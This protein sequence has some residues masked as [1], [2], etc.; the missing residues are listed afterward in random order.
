MT[1][2]DTPRK[3]I[4]V[5]LRLAPIFGLSSVNLPKSVVRNNLFS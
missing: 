5:L 1:F 4:L 2:V 3:Y